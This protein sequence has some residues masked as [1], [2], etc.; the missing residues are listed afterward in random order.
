[1]VNSEAQTRRCFASRGPGRFGECWM[2]RD[3][4]GH[5][6]SH[7]SSSRG[8]LT[9]YCASLSHFYLV[10]NSL[11]PFFTTKYITYLEGWGVFNREKIFCVEGT[12]T[13]L[14]PRKIHFFKIAEDIPN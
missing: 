7:S 4:A 2:F 3:A 5:G 1:M 8:P 12:S 13:H 10:H 9:L 14:S 11:F 6:E